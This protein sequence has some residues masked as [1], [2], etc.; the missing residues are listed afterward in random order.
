MARAPLTR[1]RV[2]KTAAYTTGALVLPAVRG[3]H[4]A[5]KLSAFF[6]DHPVPTVPAAMRKL[7]ESWAA[8]EKVDL[9]LDFVSTNGDKENTQQDKARLWAV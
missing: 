9:Q 2:L 5:G 1:R 6:W 3:V 7:C 8:K 4:A